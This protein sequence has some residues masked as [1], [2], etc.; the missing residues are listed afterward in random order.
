MIELYMVGGSTLITDI[1]R[2][3]DFPREGYRID[4]RNADCS[5]KFPNK[6]AE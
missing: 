5:P 4:G 6:H 3:V 1:K 2:R